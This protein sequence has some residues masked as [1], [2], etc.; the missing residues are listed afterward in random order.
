MSGTVGIWNPDKWL[1]FW[2]KPEDQI[3]RK[4]DDRKNDLVIYSVVQLW[5]NA[6]FTK[7]TFCLD[8]IQPKLDDR[9]NQLVI[10]SVI[11]F[12]IYLVLWIRSTVPA[13]IPGVDFIN[14]FAPYTDLSLPISNPL[15]SFSKVGRRANTRLWNLPH[16]SYTLCA[17]NFYTFLKK[18][19]V[20][21]ASHK[22]LESIT[23]IL[24][25]NKSSYYS[26][27]VFLFESVEILKEQLTLRWR[28]RYAL[29]GRGAD[30]EI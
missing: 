13:S 26:M 1:P 23:Q 8:F 7:R 21:I 18:L 25:P 14:H 10:F 5:L 24:N 6:P 15:K 2:Q 16:Y 19:L 4:A 28:C 20:N 11:C 17:V 29:G 27:S 30:G 3:N 22:L 9:I 12:S